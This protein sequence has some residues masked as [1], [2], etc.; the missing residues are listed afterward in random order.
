M[1]IKNIGMGQFVDVQSTYQTREAD[2]I[3]EPKTKTPSIMKMQQQIV[4]MS[5]EA[6]F[7][8]TTEEDNPAWKFNHRSRLN[9]V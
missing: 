6:K 8:K 2:F 9:I 5:N 7:I 1:I 3:P 4:E